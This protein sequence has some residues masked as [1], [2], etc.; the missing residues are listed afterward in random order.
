M[1]KHPLFLL[2]IHPPWPS[3]SCRYP[4]QNQSGCLSTVQTDQL[5]SPK[6]LEDLVSWVTTN[7][8]IFQK[9]KHTW[10]KSSHREGSCHSGASGA[11][12]PPADQTA[13][14]SVMD[15][16]ET[17]RGKMRSRWMGR[18]FHTW[19]AYLLNKAWMV[20]LSV[21]SSLSLSLSLGGC[22]LKFNKSDIHFLNKL[23][24]LQ[25]KCVLQYAYHGKN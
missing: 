10:F 6:E 7:E 21:V 13:T 14:Q 1:V 5:K 2:R 16:Y 20:F 19:S 24:P 17:K 9:N 15:S 11:V 4:N 25:L 23:A 18:T 3:C 8:I 12:R 22:R